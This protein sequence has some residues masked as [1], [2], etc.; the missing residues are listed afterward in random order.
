MGDVT[1]AGFGVL[2]AAG[3]ALLGW[4]AAARVRALMVAGGAVLLGLAGAWV[5]GPLGI[6]AAL[7]ALPFLKS[8]RR[9]S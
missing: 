2:A 1:V 8:R 6:A 4:G 7:A 5:F 9:A 3:L